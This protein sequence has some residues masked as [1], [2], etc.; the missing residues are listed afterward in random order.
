MRCLTAKYRRLSRQSQRSDRFI[1]VS[2]LCSR[3]PW[4]KGIDFVIGSSGRYD[5][6]IILVKSV[7]FV[8]VH[9]TREG[10]VVATINRLSSDI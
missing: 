9:V 3:L 5:S 8:R 1:R 6:D 2:L 4:R 7:L 10:I